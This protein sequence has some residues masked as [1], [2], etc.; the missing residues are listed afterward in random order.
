[1]S[2]FAKLPHSFFPHIAEKKSAINN[3]KR[4]GYGDSNLR[5]GSCNW[6]AG[7]CC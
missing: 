4:Y 7:N 6:K 2:S 5:L 3:E 1:M